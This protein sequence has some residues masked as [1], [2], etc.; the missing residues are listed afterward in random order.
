MGKHMLEV[1]ISWTAEGGKF[2]YELNHFVILCNLYFTKEDCQEK[3][4][5]DIKIKQYCPMN[6]SDPKLYDGIMI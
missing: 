6:M 3:L 5:C 2:E 1:G 4:C